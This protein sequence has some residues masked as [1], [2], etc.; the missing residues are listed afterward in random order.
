[1]VAGDAG[2]AYTYY[3]QALDRFRKHN[4]NVYVVDMLHKLGFAAQQQGD[5][6][7]ATAHLRESLALAQELDF[8]RAI[9]VALAG[10]ADVALS[11]G[12]LER[13]ARLCSAVE[14]L[15]AQTTG[16]DPDQYIVH[17]RNLAALRSQLDPA[18]LEACWAAGRTLDWEQ[19][20]AEAL[21]VAE[22]V[23]ETSRSAN[24]HSGR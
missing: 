12:D 13:A 14:A 2:T 3:E 20:I 24:H 17:Q 6:V 7:R 18:T 11:A 23:E 16:F 9:T 4:H 19:G 1:M 22:T 5:L 21:A 15:Q 8:R 10:L